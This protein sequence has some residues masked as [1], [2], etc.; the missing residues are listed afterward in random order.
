QGKAS[1]LIKTGILCGKKGKGLGF[2][3]QWLCSKLR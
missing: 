1:A 3:D 2:W